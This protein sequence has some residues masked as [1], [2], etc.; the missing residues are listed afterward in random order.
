MH[1]GRTARR[2]RLLIFYRGARDRYQTFT[3]LHNRN[4]L[5]GKQQDKHDMK[6]MNSV[7]T[8]LILPHQKSMVGLLKL[9]DIAIH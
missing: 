9:E 1:G 7:K 8:H 6:H 2:G 3:Q 5:F 4:A